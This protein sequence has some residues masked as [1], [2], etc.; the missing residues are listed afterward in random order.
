MTS[1][2]TDPRGDGRMPLRQHLDELRGCLL[3]AFGV[4]LALFMVGTMANEPLVRLLLVP[5]DTAR[6]AIV[7]SGYADPGK[8]VYIGPAEP[9]LVVLKAAFL[10]ALILGSPYVLYEI[11][12]FVAAGLYPHERAAV[13]RSL[14]FAFVL[15][16]AGM[17]FGFLV[18]LPLGLRFLGTLVDPALVGSQIAIGAYFSLLLALT[19]LMGAV[20]ELPLLMWLVVKAGLVQVET[21][22]RSRKVAILAC[23]VFGAITTPPDVVTQLLVAAPMIVLYEIGILVSRRTAAARER[24]P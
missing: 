6:D 13:M 19:I 7:A 16:A 12:R 11:W 3:R 22:A 14:P 17:A 21:F 4:V 10:A 8:L 20:F 18:L 9:F 23:L 15:M 1:V 5:W 24:T 2:S